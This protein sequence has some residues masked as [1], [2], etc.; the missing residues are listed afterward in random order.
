MHPSALRS[1]RQLLH[2]SPPRPAG[3]R[4]ARAGERRAGLGS[5][6]AA[7]PM[8]AG[9]AHAP[10]PAPAQTKRSPPIGP[11]GQRSG[12]CRAARPMGALPCKSEGISRAARAESGAAG[13]RGPAMAPAFRLGKG[14]PPRG[15][16]G[17]AEA[18]ADR[19]VS[20]RGAAA[21][22]AGRAAGLT[23]PLSPQTRKPLVEKKRRARIN[24]SLQELRLLLADSEVR[25]RGGA[26]RGRAGGPGPC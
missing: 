22:G 2:R 9:P 12:G 1:Q 14:R 20:D 4:P 3:G 23:A 25:R 26:G 17:C 16:E 8:P 11:F 10:R 24:E 19:R 21:G 5:G 7:P 18:R 6:T 13:G 15:D